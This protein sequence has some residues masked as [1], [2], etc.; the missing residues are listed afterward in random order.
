MDDINPI[1]KASQVLFKKYNTIV[2]NAGDKLPKNTSLRLT[3]MGIYA[4]S[5]PEMLIDKMSRWLGFVQGVLYAHGLI[6]LEDEREES[7]A[8]F[9]MTYGELGIELPGSVDV[10][11]MGVGGEARDLTLE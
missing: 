2:Q 10:L 4:I 1:N 7:R 3:L 8:L 5:H 6:D 11:R 9:H